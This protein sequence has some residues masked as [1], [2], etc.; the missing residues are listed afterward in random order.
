MTVER[1]PVIANLILPI[2]IKPVLNKIQAQSPEAAL[3]IKLALLRAESAFPGLILEIITK[4]TKHVDPNLDMTKALL[5]LQGAIQES[6]EYKSEFVEFN[7]RTS[8]LK[9][10]LSR[11][12]NEIS[13]RKIFLETIKEVASAI[14]KLLDCFT[15]IINQTESASRRQALEDRKRDFIKYSKKFSNKL[16]EFFREGEVQAVY[17]SAAHLIN[18]TYAIQLTMKL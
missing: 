3:D 8:Q 18:Q 2:L 14:K 7:R 13:D 9:K 6:D 17:L 15:E 11:I 12:P 16:K 5:T 1:P 4:L 10:I